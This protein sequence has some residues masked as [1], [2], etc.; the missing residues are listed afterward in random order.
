MEGVWGR[1]GYDGPT[2]VVAGIGGLGGRR[3]RACNDSSS[4]V[5]HIIS[6]THFVLIPPWINTLFLNLKSTQ[7]HLTYFTANPLES[8]VDL[9]YVNS[10]FYVPLAT[11]IIFSNISGSTPCHVKLHTMKSPPSKRKKK[12]VVHELHLQ[13]IYY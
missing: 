1:H 5:G 2:K 7:R 13:H 4:D 11:A 9:M 3:P 8:S 6:K 10:M 12:K